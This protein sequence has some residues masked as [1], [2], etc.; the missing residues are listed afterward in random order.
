[1]TPEINTLLNPPSDILSK[2]EHSYN[3]RKATALHEIKL[4]RKVSLEI[5]RD[6]PRDVQVRLEKAFSEAIKG[7][8]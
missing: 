4:A 5:M 6:C 7:L 8:T 2:E 3:I 1:M